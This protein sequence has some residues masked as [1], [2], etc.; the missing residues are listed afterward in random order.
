VLERSSND[1]AVA[2]GCI[3]V[4]TRLMPSYSHILVQNITEA[5]LLFTLTAIESNETFPKRAACGFWTKLIKPQT[6][7]IPEESK[8]RIGQVMQSFGPNFVFSLVQQFG[9]HAN[10]SDLDILCEP[11][12]ALLLHQSGTQTWLQQALSDQRFASQQ[13]P[14]EG[15]GTFVQALLR[16]RSDGKMV[17]EVV[18]RFWAACRGTVTS[19]AS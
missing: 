13:V 9:G 15:R 8:E 16:A 19:F 7:A 5:V 17:K 12:K 14:M 3:E 11:L 2:A 18:R 10:R 4:L 1:P 6:E